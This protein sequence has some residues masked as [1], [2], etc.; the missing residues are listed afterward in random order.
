MFI[1]TKQ[2]GWTLIILSLLLI[3]LVAKIKVDHDQRDTYLCQAY[4]QIPDADMTQ[5]PGHQSNTSWYFTLGFVLLAALGIL[6]IL[7][8]LP[9]RIKEMP[10]QKKVD[11]SKLDQEELKIYRL[12]QEKEGSM[13]QS[14]LVRETGFTKVHVTRVLDKLEGKGIIERKRRGMTNIVVVR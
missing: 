5:C 12:L 4:H 13:Y 6:G 3:L 7:L 10:V 11:L 1:T 2:A 9:P 14:D 8:L